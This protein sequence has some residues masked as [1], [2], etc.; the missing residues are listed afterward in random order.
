MALSKDPVAMS[1]LKARGLYVALV[2][3]A[4]FVLGLIRILWRVPRAGGRTAELVEMPVMLAIIML[5]ARW[6]VDTLL[7]RPRRW[8]DLASVLSRMACL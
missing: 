8:D 4:G 1:I 7:R 2:F 5:A 3:E 6:I